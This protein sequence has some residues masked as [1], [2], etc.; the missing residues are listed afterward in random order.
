MQHHVLLNDLT[1]KQLVHREGAKKTCTPRFVA[2]D[3]RATHHYQRTMR[4]EY[5]RWDIH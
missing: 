4:K 5:L 2:W 3:G 1:F